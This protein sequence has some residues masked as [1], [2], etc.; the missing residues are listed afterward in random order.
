MNQQSFLDN[1]PTVILNNDGELLLFENFFSDIKIE[2]LINEVEWQQDQIQMFGKIHP[3]PRLTAFQ[4]LAGI[5]Y[6]YSKITMEAKPWTPIVFKIFS[7]LKHELN[8]DFNSVLLNYYRDGNDHMS[9][10]SDD[11]P[12]LGS[13]PTIASASFGAT[14]KFSLKHRFNNQKFEVNLQD[15][16]LLIMQGE[17]QHF[18]LHKINKKTSEPSPRVN[19]TFRKIL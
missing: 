1:T 12:E 11:E 3:L 9:F 14:R 13:N 10:H 17:L 18:W 16:S 4:G 6:T 15:K 7:K 2:Q 5:Q 19:L 8:L